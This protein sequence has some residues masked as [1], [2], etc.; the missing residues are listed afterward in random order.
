MHSKR[1]LAPVVIIIIALIIVAAISGYFIVNK[2]TSNSNNQPQTNTPIINTPP[3]TVETQPEPSTQPTATPS[4]TPTTR[5]SIKEFS[6]TAKRFTFTPSTITVNL[7]DTVKLHITS[8][9]TLHGIT[10]PDYGI[11]KNLPAGSTVDIQFVA[12]KKGTFTFQCSVF[13]GDGHSGMRGQLIVQ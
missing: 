4:P 5:P 13:C 11:A 7:G 1:A 3:Q 10:I 6:M 8:Q 2:N 12:D 9:D